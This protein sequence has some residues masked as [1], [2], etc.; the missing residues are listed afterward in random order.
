MTI[1]SSDIALSL[2]LHNEEKHI[3]RLAAS[4]LKQTLPAS[5]IYVTD[6]NSTDNSASLLKELLPDADIYL[7]NLNPGFATAHNRN[8]KKAFSE[9]AKAVFILNTDTEMD[10]NCIS[11]IDDFL[12]KNREIGV[13]APIVFY[14][15]S[16]GKTNIVQS[17]RINAD[18]KRGRI[19]PVDDK[20][21]YTSENL[22]EST[23]VNYVTGTA[24]VI[25]KEVFEL[26]GG[27]EESGFL[28][29]E[30]MDFCYRASLKGIRM[31]VVKDA[32]VWH[33]HVW[34]KKN[35]SGLCNEYYYI[36]RNR[37]R[38]FKR[39]SLKNSLLRYILNETLVSPLRIHW[40][41]KTGGRKLVY[42][43]YL[44]I[45]HGLKNMSGINT[46]TD[47]DRD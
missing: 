13:I 47:F 19:T 26:I 14:G 41:L 27:F 11:V 25:K 32:K 8:M 9:N 39:Y 6:N 37:V 2:V 36:N 33:F 30:E 15:N 28:Y 7:S 23:E 43:F 46:Q 38:F 31:A 42:Y 16:D 40:A 24:C 45:L 22:P 18:F 44:G 34:S 4:V 10:D 17:F 3:P 12:S 5:K 21:E 35:S 20:R 29:G 1:S